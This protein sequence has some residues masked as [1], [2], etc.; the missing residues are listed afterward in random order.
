MSWSVSAFVSLFRAPIFETAIAPMT[1]SARIIAPNAMPRRYASRKLLKR[2]IRFLPGKQVVQGAPAGACRFFRSRCDRPH[3]RHFECS[4]PVFRFI[5][6]PSAAGPAGDRP[7]NDDG[8]ARRIRTGPRRRRGDVVASLSL[9]DRELAD[10]ALELLRRAGE[11][12]RRR[13][14]LL[15][16]GARLLCRGRDLLRGGRGLLGD[17]GD[18][19]HVALDLLRARGDLLDRGRD[20]VDA[21]ALVLHGLAELEERLAGLLDGGDAVL[22][23]AG[24]VPDDLA[25]LGGLGLDLADEARDRAGGRLALL[26]QLADLL[27]DDREAAALLAGAGGLDGR[28]QR[29]QVRLLGD[30]GDRLDDAADALGLRAQLADRLGRLQR[31]VAHRA[32]GLGSLGDGARALLGGPTGRHGGLGGLLG[33]V[34]AGGAR[35]R[36]LL[37]GQL[38][39]LHRA[40]LALGALGDLAHGGRD[41]ADGATGLLG[42]RGHL[43]RRGRQRLRRVRHVADEPAELRAGLVVARDGLDHLRAD[44]VERAADVADLVAGGGLDLRRLRDDRLRQVAARHRLDRVGQAGDAVIA[45]H[46]ET[47]DDDLQRADDGRDDEEREAERGQR[48]EDRGD[49]DRLAAARG[50]GGGGRGRLGDVAVDL[51]GQGVA[52]LRGGGLGGDHGRVE[53]V[54]RAGAV[55]VVADGLGARAADRRAGRRGELRDGGLV[56][57]EQRARPGVDRG[58][59]RLEVGGVGGGEGIG[60]LGDAVLGGEVAVVDVEVGR[61]QVGGGLQAMLDGQHTLH[62]DDVVRRHR[63]GLVAERAELRDGDRADDDQREDYDAEGDPEAIGEPQ[64]VETGHWGLQGGGFGGRGTAV[65]PAASPRA[66]AL[67]RRTTSI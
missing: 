23:L 13:G 22:G 10:E 14:D 7:G 26:G 28:V 58:V 18:L 31:A 61:R 66:S 21:D 33:V 25:G 44:V 57:A 38:G 41:L 17:R 55:L 32:H 39:L 20:L 4:R 50:G 16:R 64:V 5:E 52:G 40:H 63:L 59:E 37:G 49:H 30:A 47:L 60:L 27:G 45:Q 65:G 24:A 42:G 34:G 48:G 19:G 29:Q 54:A 11:L 35:R 46:P 56:L 51:T 53:V 8:P 6:H 15:R 12:L 62:R 67:H 36:D 43:L 9:G 2:D 1:T 3:R